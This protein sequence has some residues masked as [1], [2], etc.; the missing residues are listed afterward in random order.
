MVV[1]HLVASRTMT[2]ISGFTVA[3]QTVSA[4]RLADVC[5]DDPSAACT[6]V[7]ERT[8]VDAL[9]TVA[10]Y[11]MARIPTV[12]LIW[13]IAFLVNRLVRLVIK[14]V[15]NRIAG[16]ATSGRLQKMRDK[17]PDLLLNTGSVGLRS[18]ARAKTTTLVLRSASTVVVYG[19]A[20]LY[21]LTTLGLRV[22]PL[23]AGA[24]I[25]G[26]A[27]GFGAQSTVRDFLG[28]AFLLLEDQFGVG[29]SIDVAS[30][31]D[32]TPGISGVVENVTLRVTSVRDVNGTIWHIPNG[33]IRRVGNKSQGW[34]RALLDIPVPYGTDIDAASETILDVARQVSVSTEFGHEILGAPEVWGVEELGPDA[35]VI[36]LVV[37]TRPGTQWPIMRALRARVHDA[38]QANGVGHPFTQHTVWFR[39]DA[40]GPLP[41]DAADP[42]DAT[43]EDDAPQLSPE[44]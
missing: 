34:A 15:G 31:V 30:N 3:A 10:D 38:L 28:G 6:W 23:V 26:V 27:L 20:V 12:A 29:D 39:S 24:G 32:G 11:L 14:R 22:G 17:T 21:S 37:K 13:L 5:G 9:A 35:V 33:E 19:L 36:R 18:A 42:G 41:E 8:G 7:L 40:G 16:A 1:W 44:T 25:V 4:K 2:V 43:P